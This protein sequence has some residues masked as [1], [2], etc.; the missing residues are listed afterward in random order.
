MKN[1]KSLKLEMPDCP[2]CGSSNTVINI[3]DYTNL[4]R[5][6]AS[7]VSAVMIG[8]PLN[9]ISFTCNHCDTNFKSKGM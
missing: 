5:I 7:T 8:V 1:H 2:E 4:I 9:D 6:P 3:S